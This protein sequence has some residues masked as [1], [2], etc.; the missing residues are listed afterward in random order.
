M[1]KIPIKIATSLEIPKSKGEQIVTPVR[2]VVNNGFSSVGSFPSTKV[3]RQVGYES[4]L[5]ADLAQLLEFD[6]KIDYFI[7]QPCKIPYKDAKEKERIYTPDFMAL[8]KKDIIPS[9]WDNPIIYEVKYKEDLKNS[10]DELRYKFQAAFT[11]SSK[12]H[13]R[14]KVLTEE[15]IRT[16]YLINAKFLLRYKYQYAELGLLNTVLDTLEFLKEA[17]PFEIIATATNNKSRQAQ[18]LYTLWSLTANH[19]IGCNFKKQIT[20]STVL[21]Y[22]STPTKKFKNESAGY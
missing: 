20:M 2:K 14:F 3:K 19:Y 4:S 15:H 13:W 10:F 8:F 22:K 6:E 21:W 1:R 18:L 11:Y 17:T 9:H 7:E 12:N 16:E 5:E